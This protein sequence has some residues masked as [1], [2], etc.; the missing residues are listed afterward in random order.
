MA[1]K[2]R[3][4]DVV[5]LKAIV[6]QGP[7]LKVRMTEEGDVEYLIEYRDANDETQQRWFKEDALES[8]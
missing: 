7:V 1:S 3:K 4:D 2:F 5:R 6:P 8:A